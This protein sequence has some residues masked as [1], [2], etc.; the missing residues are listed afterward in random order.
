[1][2][3]LRTV[4]VL[5]L[6]VVI[7]LGVVGAGGFFYLTRRPFPQTDGTTQ[8]AALH[9]PVTV[10]RDKFGIPHIYA[11]S[12]HDLFFAQ[13]YVQAQDRLWEMEAGRMGI[14]GRTSE[15]RP[16]ASALEQD[17]FVRTLGW[18]RAAE[19]DFEATSEEFKAILQAYSDGVNAFIS[20][21]QDS[22]PIEFFIVGLF[23]SKGPGY[24]PDPWTPVDSLQWAKV[25]AWRLSG[26]WE[27][28]WLRS[29]ILA[30][31]GEER[32]K[33]V[34]ADLEPP[35]DYEN[36]PIIV[37]EEV[38]WER[39]PA[40]VRGLRALD[41]MSGPRG[42]DMGSNSWAVAGS[43]STTGMP[44]LA[45]DPHLGYQMPALWYF[46][47]LHCEPVRPDCPF[48]LIGAS[49]PG[50]PGV[51]IGHNARIVWSMTNV[52][53]DVQD[54][55]LEKVDGSQYEF[56]G[57]ML[58]LTIVPET[59]TIKGKL[60]EGYES[61][62]NETATYDEATNTT[63]ITLNVRYTRH[64]P[65][66]SD[67]DE[68]TAE[69][70]PQYAVAFAWTAINAPE[71]TLESVL[72]FNAAQNWEEFR[73]AL[74]LFG[75]PS[76]NMVYADVDGNIG[77]QT[78]GRIPIRASGD[79]LLPVP[80]WTGEYEWTGT[81]PFDELP[82]AFNPAQG[83]IATANNAVVGP[84]YPYF[85]TTEWDRGY[86]AR[87]IVDLIEAKDKLSPDDMAAIQ[88]DNFN[89][90]A[91]DIVVYLDNLTVDGDAQKALDAIRSWDFNDAVDSSGAAAYEVFWLYLLRSTFDDD[92]GDLASAYVDGGDVNSQAT[93]LLLAQPDSEW[94]DDTTTLDVV[95]TRDDIL[96]KSLADATAALTA[97]FGADPA[98]WKW[99]ALHQVTFASQAL[100]DS[101]VAF[102]FNRGPF[103][104]NG[105]RE[106]VN[107]SGVSFGQA[108]P[109]DPG[110]PAPKLVSIFQSRG[111]PSLRQIVDLSDL[112][113]SHF[114]HTTGQSGLPYH[115]HYD[116]MI[117]PWLNI[118][119]APMWWER[120][121]VEQNAEGTLS[122][123]P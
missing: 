106:I 87:R 108:Y 105:G 71:H 12:V 7:V 97:E 30:K 44:L 95:E 68:T 62:P 53:P 102:I 59:W 25:M 90:S 18:R 22:L 29:Q 26:N 114:I 3:I 83:Y 109:D 76:Q 88:G 42:N 43:R 86:R 70:D 69:I 60:P 72:G 113:A 123:T 112:D 77:Y 15:L 91:P 33:A 100:G 56:Q 103:A 57:K 101:P 52:G 10:I 1:M 64:G 73:E 5:I 98:G 13:G 61:S 45:N 48:D 84:D 32:G 79:G 14:S 40:A 96:K 2:R 85:L 120:Q 20:A 81:I 116:D 74:R 67:V 122:L 80:G 4:L 21:H 58:D 89:L 121:S 41:A 16:S 99:G 119:F 6:I 65:L 63:T 117:Q 38:A 17:K 46:N 23:G 92:L 27:S 35:Y 93:T 8:L 82:S 28:E 11:S 49:L 55:F 94:W 19:A 75:T 31:F 24:R 36:R 34:L 47:S 111:G 51:V 110:D 118:E 50:A 115:P 107:A 37:P 54:L 66:I 78:P 39:V 104:V 9:A